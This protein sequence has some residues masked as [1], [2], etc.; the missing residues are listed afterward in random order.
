[1]AAEDAVSVSIGFPMLRS[2]IAPR[3]TNRWLAETSGPSPRRAGYEARQ[4]TAALTAAQ[5]ASREGHLRRARRQAVRWRRSVGTKARHSRTHQRASSNYGG[6]I[7]E[8][9]NRK[10]CS[11]ARSQNAR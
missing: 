3:A 10:C 2:A 5:L 7:E 11:S 4:E 1:M 8:A 6:A 9:I